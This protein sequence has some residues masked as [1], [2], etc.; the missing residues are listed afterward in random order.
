[1]QIDPCVCVVGGESAAGVLR[2]DLSSYSWTDPH[3]PDPGNNI[4]NVYDSA[5]PHTAEGKGDI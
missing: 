4:P 3:S 2:R 5:A 1:M